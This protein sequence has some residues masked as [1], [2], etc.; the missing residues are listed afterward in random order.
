MV[1][2]LEY[3]CQIFSRVPS[4]TAA[5]NAAC[6]DWAWY[7]NQNEQKQANTHYIPYKSV[8]GS[9]RLIQPF[10]RL[11]FISISPRSPEEGLKKQLSDIILCIF[12]ACSPCYKKDKH[13]SGNAIK[14]VI[15]TFQSFSKFLRIY[16]TFPIILHFVTKETVQKT[17]K[18]SWVCVEEHSRKMAASG[19]FFVRCHE[20]EGK[21]WDSQSADLKRGLLDA[22][23]LRSVQ[24]AVT[25]RNIK[26]NYWKR[27]AS[28]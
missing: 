27:K 7:C 24:C 2:C 15:G 23:H 4:R 3:C 18:N 21:L 28:G 12:N 22:V 9:R 16:S 5:S 1:S 26:T 20:L 25:Y 10:E 17:I 6:K 8:W 19:Y 11:Q 14:R 13:T